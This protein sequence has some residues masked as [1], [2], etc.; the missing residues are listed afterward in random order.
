M[1][2]DKKVEIAKDDGIR[3]LLDE[4]RQC[5]TQ[6][7]HYEGVANRYLTCVA[8]GYPIIIGGIS[9]LY[10]M[11]SDD[12]NR[13]VVSAMLLLTFLVGLTILGLLLSNRSNYAVAAR[14]MNAI[15]HYFLK[16]AEDLNFIKENRAFLDHDKPDAYN[17]KSTSVRFFDIISILNSVIGAGCVF[18]ILA[19]F[20]IPEYVIWVVAAFLV[21]ILLGGQK[22][23]GIRYLKE[24]DRILKKRLNEIVSS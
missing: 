13:I 6:I 4:Y 10:D 11:L 22:L 15:R 14:Q 5:Y 24:Q 1:A 18:F 2:K 20:E 3:F 19:Y 8:A 7:R 23:W 16:N 9:A 17:P 12:Y 21:L